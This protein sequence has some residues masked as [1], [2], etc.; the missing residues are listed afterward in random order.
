LNILDTE[1]I[2]NGFNIPGK[3]HFEGCGIPQGCLGA[4]F[5]IGRV[6][7]EGGTR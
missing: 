6:E 1:S 3:T 4:V 5:P 7:V 2:M